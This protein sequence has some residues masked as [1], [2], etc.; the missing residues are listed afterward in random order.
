MGLLYLYL[1]L[2]NDNIFSG[3]NLLNIKCV[4]FET[5]LTLRKIQRFITNV[6]QS[7]LHS[8]EF[9]IELKIFPHIFE[10]IKFIK[11]PFPMGAQLFHANRR[12]ENHEDMTTPIDGF[13]NFAKAPKMEK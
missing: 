6:Q 5:F 12:E 10:N 9:S 3:K 13:R 7:L 1:Y 4:L 2:I 11:K 8:S